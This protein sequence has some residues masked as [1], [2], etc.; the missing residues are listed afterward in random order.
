MKI[1]KI[2]HIGIAAK[3]IGQAAPFWTDILGLPIRTQETVAEQEIAALFLPIG[4]S[5]I[6]VLESTTQDGAI[7]RFIRSRGEGMQHIA[8]R[9]DNI[10]AALSE[11]KQKGIRLIDQKPREGAD[12]SRIAFIHPES[13]HG[14]LLELVEHQPL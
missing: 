11:L 4:E 9:V 13:T 6:E 8:L 2:D 3:S 10:D 7:A 14:I 5:E 12:G 1:L